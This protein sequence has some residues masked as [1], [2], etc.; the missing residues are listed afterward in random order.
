MPDFEITDNLTGEKH[1]VSGASQDEA[2]ANFKQQ[3]TSGKIPSPEPMGTG[4]QIATGVGRGLA[5][6]KQAA[7]NI[8]S[9]P[10]AAA[11]VNLAMRARDQQI[12]QRGGLG[13]AGN[14]AEGVTQLPAAAAG[15]AIGS[16][17]GGPAGGVIGGAIGGGLTG[18]VQPVGGPDYWARKPQ[19]I[20]MGTALGGGT[21]L[22]LKTLAGFLG[23]KDLPAAQ[24]WLQSKGVMLTP[25]QLGSGRGVIGE[26][27]KRLE[28]AAKSWPIL[29]R[30]IVNAQGQSIESFNRAIAGQVLEPIGET[31]SAGAIKHELMDEVSSKVDAA[32]H[33]L[34]PRM[35]M[36]F[37]RD[38]SQAL[39]D[40]RINANT[41]PDTM[42]KQFENIMNRTLMPI[43]Q[44]GQIT[45]DDIKLIDRTFRDEARAFMRQ[46]LVK[47]E[48]DAK[49]MGELFDNARQAVR[50]ALGRQNRPEL[51][52]RLDNIDKSYAM[53]ARFQAAGAK[54]ATSGGQFTPAELLSVI[55][56]QDKS[57]R[58]RAFATGDALLQTYAEFGQE[59]IPGKLPDSG[60]P[61]RFLYNQL[62]HDNLF[63]AMLNV[64]GAT[65]AGLP[66]TRPGMNV[67]NA[68]VKP[69]PTPFRQAGAA[70]RG[71][72][73]Y[74]AGLGARAS[75]EE[76]QYGGPQQ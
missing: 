33:A 32:Y 13:V 8:F 20:M 47:G 1:R 69:S 22:G 38:L 3:F 51:V 9:D 40:I 21:E 35:Q 15:G 6:Y 14:I 41:L 58:K 60:T 50:D 11:N 62:A 54:R 31:I 53:L 74:L 64:G 57:V 73:P 71:A 55:K 34:L 5:G 48:R 39:G 42:Q 61:E 67:V 29:G 59:V 7:A 52:Q 28:D 18:L 63:N 30:F 24:K 27:L 23:P 45:G 66:Y 44:K 46:G 19:D 43:V 17:I 56:S 75:E 70:V 26:S 4:E 25:G 37:D 76:P 49:N 10:K 72:A 65:T 2:M 36:S 12:A 16:M 68:L